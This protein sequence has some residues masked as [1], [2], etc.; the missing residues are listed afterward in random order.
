VCLNRLVVFRMCGEEKVKVA[1]LVLFSV[2]LVGVG[3][4]ILCIGKKSL[5][6]LRSTQKT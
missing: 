4:V 5:F 2:F 1:H 6:V 3:V